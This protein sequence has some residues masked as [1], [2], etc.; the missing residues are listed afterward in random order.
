MGNKNQKL[1][2]EAI[3][4]EIMNLR[5]YRVNSE[6]RS[7]TIN[8][9]TQLYKLRIEEEKIEQELAISA[10]DEAMKQAE[11]ES[12]ARDRLFNIGLQ[13]GLTGLSLIAYNAWLNRGLKFQETGTFTDPM[14]RNLLSRI[15]PIKK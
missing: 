6:E 14:T 3:E 13:I 1:L 10:R 5:N 12:K 9:L 7:D 4:R 8:S 2:D 15:V 11:L